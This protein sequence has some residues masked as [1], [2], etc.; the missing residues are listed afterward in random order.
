M[1]DDKKMKI[2]EPNNDQN[3]K[4]ITQTDRIKNFAYKHRKK[5]IFSLGSLVIIGG[6]AFFF[7]K[8]PEYGE[9]LLLELRQLINDG[10]PEIIDVTNLSESELENLIEEASGIT[11]EPVEAD[12]GEF[13]SARRLGDM[14]GKSAQWVNKRLCELGY[15]EG[16]PGNWNV[17]EKGKAVSSINAYDNEVGG[18]YHICSPYY[19]WKKDIVYELDDPDAYR[20]KINSIRSE[21]G[22]EPME[23]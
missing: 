20:E 14:I 21:L 2:Q 15:L 9:R 5:I 4:E 3:R 6:T 22:I 1:E 8:N 13:Y 17:T 7:K 19:E 11:P 16:D 23:K 10:D 18:Y 12:L